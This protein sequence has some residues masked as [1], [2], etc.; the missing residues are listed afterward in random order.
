MVL[1]GGTGG[2]VYPALAAAQELASRGWEIAWLGARDGFEARVVPG[3]GFPIDVVDV[4]KVRGEG[5][6]AW[7]LAPVRLLRAMVEAA[8]VLRRRRPAV[9]LGMGG[10]V[11]GPGGLVAR[12]LGMPLVIHEQN[13]IPGLTNRWLARVATRV[14]QAFPDTFPGGSRAA[15][16][17]NPVRA[18]IVALPRPE[19]RYA[20]RSGPGRLLVIGGSLG[21]R[22]LNDAVPAALSTLPAAARPLV[23]HQAGR[24]KAEATEAAYRAAGVVADVSEYLIDMAGAYGW[25]DL[26][27]CRAGALT[28]SELAAAGVP[29]VLVPYPFAVDDH[30]TRNARFLAEAGAGVLLPQTELTAERLGRV[31]TELI[32]DPAG[33]RRMAEAARR[34]ARPDAARRVADACEEVA[35]R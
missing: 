33:L 20:D 8:A 30:Q 13:A 15:T 10:F 27:V 1:A 3:Y 6:G 4:R 5:L 19:Q 12:L 16:V 9:V 7:L 34:L 2:H 28:V 32:G 22:A 17:G 35:G 25:A 31:L 26:V 24:G 14:L 21:A 11:A 29:A 23:R 18:E